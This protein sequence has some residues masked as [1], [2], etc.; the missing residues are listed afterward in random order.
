MCITCVVLFIFI[1]YICMLEYK[2]TN[3][4]LFLVKKRHTKRE[5][6]S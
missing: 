4:F 1:Y 3:T 5:A 6:Y 2:E